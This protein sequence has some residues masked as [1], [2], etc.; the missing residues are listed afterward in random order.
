M[1]FRYSWDCAAMNAF[2]ENQ[3][4][5]CPL[6]AQNA[7]HI[8]GGHEGFCVEQTR[9]GKY[10]RQAGKLNVFDYLFPGEQI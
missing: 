2:S 10:H 7:S 4:T 5:K 3:K 9:F 8:A 6:N 1:G